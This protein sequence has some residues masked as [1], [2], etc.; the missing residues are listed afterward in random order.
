MMLKL[1]RTVDELMVRVIPTDPFICEITRSDGV[2]WVDAPKL[3]IAGSPVWT[4]VVTGPLARFDI[5]SVDVDAVI[6]SGNRKVRLTV[7]GLVWAAGHV[8][9][10]NA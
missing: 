8:N 10:E 3:E 1:G 7:G 9:V 4:S 5:S 2:T 6:A